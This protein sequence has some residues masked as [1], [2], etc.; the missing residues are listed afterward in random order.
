MAS[1]LITMSN[2]TPNLRLS[3]FRRRHFC[4]LNPRPLTRFKRNAYSNLAALA[5]VIVV[6]HG[7]K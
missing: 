2:V 3:G 6:K 1:A 4:F 7:D 5:A